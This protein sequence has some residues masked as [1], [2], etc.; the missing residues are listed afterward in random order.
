MYHGWQ[1][2]VPTDSTG[3]YR[4]TDPDTKEEFRR[5]HRGVLEK[6]GPTLLHVGDRRSEVAYLD[7]F[8]SQMFAHRGSYGYSSDEAYLTL[9]HAELQPEV[10]YEDQI[11]KEG[12][13]AFKVLV[14]ANC[15][16]LTSSVA[17]RTQAFQQRGGTLAP[18]I[19]PDILLTT[20]T[21]SKKGDVDQTAILA[22]AAQ[23]RNALDTRYV[24]P[25]D[26]TN[27][28]IVARVRTS[29]EGDYVF[30][31]NDHR[32]FGTYVGQHGMVMENGLPS[33][34]E[35]TLNRRS[36]HV[37]DLVGGHEI[38]ADT[39]ENK[40]HWPVSLA[41]CDGRVYLVTPESISAVK[42]T[43]PDSIVRGNP[44]SVSAQID[45]QSGKPI[46]AALPLD[47]E[48]TDPAGRV[49]EFSG[50]YGATSGR[51]SL[52]IDIAR[53]DAP[54]VW[55]IRARELASGKESTVY[56]RVTPP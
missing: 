37:Y 55:Q 26:S 43:A 33:A 46:D 24:R 17:Q 54:G 35:L 14:L 8:T 13:D 25:A 21:R 15:D 12:L 31:V 52:R 29:G 16:V 5:L 47:L 34:G 9:L 10:I 49:A 39:R 50:Y 11:T 51:L 20:V 28:E 36:G 53:N 2:L 42:L 1:A 48:I 4:Y 23:L 32:E 22:A 40:L 56:F 38:S 41:P 19:K 27:P 6:L 45:D 3:G 44:V 7:S 30:V 18:A